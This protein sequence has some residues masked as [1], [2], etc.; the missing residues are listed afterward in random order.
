MNIGRINEYVEKLKSNAEKTGYFL[1]PDEEFLADLAEGLLTNK[2]RYGYEACPCR[3]SDGIMEKDLDIICPCDYRDIDLDEYGACFCALY[4]NKAI[5]EGKEEAESIPDRRKSEK[6]DKNLASG[7]VKSPENNLSYPVWRCKVC[8]Y[9][10]ARKNP[11]ELCPI[12]K[13]QKE[14]FE[15]FL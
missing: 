10:C 2:D 11:P 13:A 8:G 7:T 6:I 14:R 4:V 12:C 15:R 5:Y 1:N 3:L 9:L